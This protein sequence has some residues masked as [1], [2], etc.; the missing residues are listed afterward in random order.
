M[1][2]QN[3][4][5]AWDRLGGIDVLRDGGGSSQ[6]KPAGGAEAH[7]ANDILADQL[8]DAIRKRPSRLRREPGSRRT[9]KPALDYPANREPVTTSV[10]IPASAKMGISRIAVKDWKVGLLPVRSDRRVGRIRA[11]FC[12]PDPI[13]LVADVDTP[14]SVHPSTQ[15]ILCEQSRGRK[16]RY[17]GATPASD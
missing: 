12:P 17:R 15:S 14:W 9:E 4:I 6:S 13:R 3:P 7:F 10:S 2:N 16:A 1:L 8:P 5:P 11:R